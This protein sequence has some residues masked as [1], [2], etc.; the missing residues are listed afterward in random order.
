MGLKLREEIMIILQI[1]NWDEVAY[2]KPFF[3]K[4]I[5]RNKPIFASYD[6]KF[7]IKNF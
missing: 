1:L 6:L 5:L 3:Q 7:Q 4:A 2:C